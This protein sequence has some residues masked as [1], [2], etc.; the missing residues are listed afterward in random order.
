MLVI[1]LFTFTIC[2]AQTIPTPLKNGYEYY[3]N[4]VASD[5]VGSTKTTW[6]HVMSPDKVEVLF[7]NQQISLSKLS[8][9]ANV[10]VK[11]QGKYFITDTTY[12]DILSV[13]YFGKTPDTL[14]NCPQFTT[15][16]GWIY[17]RTL[18]SR[19]AGTIK[20][21]KYKSFFRK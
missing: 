18:V 10:G 8:D 5:T 6:S 2:K 14:I 1:S 16:L 19:N 3:Y 20:I 13:T 21:N 9:T 12:T 4:G 17:Y 7:S 11:F 15:K